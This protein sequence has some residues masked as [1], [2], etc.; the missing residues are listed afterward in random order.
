M[1][2]LSF[3]AIRMRFRTGLRSA[4]V[5]NATRLLGYT[6]ASQALTML[7]APFLSR[8]FSPATFGAVGIFVMFATA[9]NGLSCLSYL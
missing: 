7:A 6:V 1:T 5:K 2:G 3:A 8:L 4:F 9:V